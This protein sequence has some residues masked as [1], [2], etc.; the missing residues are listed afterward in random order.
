LDPEYPLER[1]HYMI[2]DSGVG[3]L[4]S[5]RALFAALGE[6]PAGVA[7]WCLED[8]QPMLASFSSDELPFISLPQHQ[9]YLIYTSGSTGKPKGVVVSHGEIAMHCQAV[10][11]R[12]DMQPDDCELHFYSINF[13]AAT[14][15][16]LVPLLSGARVVLRAQGQWDAEEICTLIREQQVNILGF[17]PSYGSQLAQWL[18]TQGQTLPVRMCITGGEALTGEHLQRIRAVFQPELFFNA[19][20]PTETVVMPL[21]SLAPQ[22]LEEGEA[23]VPI[24]RIVGARVAYILDADLALVPQGASG[25]L[26]IGGAGLAQGYHQRPGM[27]AERFVA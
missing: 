11:R 17:T 27:T 2:E 15:R 23:S 20:G 19:Y 10:I 14:E 3:L 24:G 25:E 21:A 9:A 8:D 13:D 5:D 18:A 22:R 26:Y 7:R 6:L 1:L 12:F 4:L 16:L